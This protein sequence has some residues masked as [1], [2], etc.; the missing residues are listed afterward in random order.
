MVL[1][2]L[3]SVAHVRSF[4]K[5]K[6]AGRVDSDQAG[7]TAHLSSK[8]FGCCDSFAAHI[9]FDPAIWDVASTMGSRSHTL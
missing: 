2:F 8:K 1:V 4:A 9:T 6:S 3:V 7:H 5:E